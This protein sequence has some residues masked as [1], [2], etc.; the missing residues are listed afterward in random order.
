LDKK[1]NKLKRGKLGEI[2]LARRV[3]IQP[4][5][6]KKESN[7]SYSKDVDK[8]DYGCLAEREKAVPG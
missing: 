4:P 6:W 8:N 7:L 1:S 3:F 5:P 2:I